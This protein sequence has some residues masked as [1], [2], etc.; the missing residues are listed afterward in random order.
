MFVQDRTDAIQAV[1][2]HAQRRK[3]AAI[4]L[5]FHETYPQTVLFCTISTKII[6]ARNI[7]PLSAVQ[8]FIYALGFTGSAWA[9]VTR[10]P[11]GTYGAGYVGPV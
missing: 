1:N 5:Q 2:L 11:I 7:A 10:C 3:Q 4:P 9:C 6:T 8:V